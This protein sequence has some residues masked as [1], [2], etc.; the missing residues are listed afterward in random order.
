M[1]AGL[2]SHDLWVRTK[3]TGSSRASTAAN[4]DQW[5]FIAAILG[6]AAHHVRRPNGFMAYLG[7]GIF[8][9]YIVHQTLTVVSFALLSP[10]GLPLFI[11]V[12]AVLVA[13]LVGCLAAYELARRLGVW[14]LLMGVSPSNN[15][16]SSRRQTDVTAPL[17]P[18]LKLKP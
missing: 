5:A 16:L 7:S 12:G 10:L 6:Y 1:R 14:G 18:V 15:K 11:E 8:C 13:T 3:P 2:T 4:V 9:F 17:S